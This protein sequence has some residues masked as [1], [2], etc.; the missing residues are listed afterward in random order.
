M[1]FTGPI[2]TTLSGM[3]LDS[4]YKFYTFLN[5]VLIKACSFESDDGIQMNIYV[6][7]RYIW[8]QYIHGQNLKVHVFYWFCNSVGLVPFAVGIRFEASLS[9]AIL[10]YQ[11][12]RQKKGGKKKCVTTELGVWGVGVI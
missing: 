2:K 4:S 6:H 12:L 7:N 10:A 1:Y 3:F 9:L 11:S 5:L 8:P